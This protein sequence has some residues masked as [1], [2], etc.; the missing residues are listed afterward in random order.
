MSILT[1]DTITK[2]ILPHLTS[3]NKGPKLSDNKL[4]GIVQLILHRLK[5]GTQWRE[6]PIKQYMDET[7]S[8]QS[9]FHHFNNWCKKGCWQK[10]LEAL[11]IGNKKHLDLSSIQIDGTHTPAKR[12]GEAVAYQGRKSCKTTNMLCISDKNGVL[13]GG[14]QPEAGNHNDL[15]DIE[16]H[17]CEIIQMLENV[18]IN[19]DGLFLNADAGFDSVNLRELC[20]RYGII[21]NFCLNKRNG[22][23]SDR[24]DYFD[25]LLYKERT[26][27]EH[28]FAWLDAFK[29]LLVRYEKTSRNWFNLNLIG[30]MSIFLRKLT[31]K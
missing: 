29:A 4:V 26:V 25:D 1:K 14:S 16:K 12:G 24:D 17:F 22:N 15:Y 27:I 19:T 9:V 8:W 21:P 20:F 30:F 13:I 23:I 3:G 7:Y 2:E 28:S 18:G 5:T 6:L 31:P 10:A 11:V